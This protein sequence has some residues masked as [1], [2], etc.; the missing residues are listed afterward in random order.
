MRIIAVT[1]ATGFV[2]AHVLEQIRVACPDAVL[3]ALAR[4]Q[5]PDRPGVTWMPGTLDDPAALDDLVQDAG[6]VIHLAGAVKARTASGFYAVNGRGTASLLAAM[7]RSAPAAGLIHVSSLAAR[8]PAL[9]PY[10]GSKA[11]AEEMVTGLGRDRS[12]TILRPP[13]VYGPGDAEILK[14]LRMARRGILPAPGHIGNRVSLIHARDLAELIARL[15]A[16]DICHRAVLEVDDGQAGGYDYADLARILA[17]VLQRPVRPLTVPYP[18]LSASGK[19]NGLARRLIGQ[20]PMLTAGKAR[21]LCH[22]DWVARSGQAVLADI[23]TPQIDLSAGLR[24]TVDAA[25]RAGHL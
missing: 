20:T 15:A 9:S 2:G 7:A 8:Q 6:V 19:L 4:R 21:E 17:Q 10:A 16:R 3:R 24:E 5:Q 25:R 23:W 12:W 22:P 14:L 11:A 18:L 1:G 13:G